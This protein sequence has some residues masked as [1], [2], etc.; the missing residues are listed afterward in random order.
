MGGGGL[1]AGAVYSQWCS[2]AAEDA[3]HDSVWSLRSLFLGTC[4][5]EA[6]TESTLA[7][8]HLCCRR[9]E[10]IERLPRHSPRDRSWL[11]STVPWNTGRGPLVNRSILY[12][13]DHPSVTGSLNR[14]LNR[15]ELAA[16]VP[17]CRDTFGPMR[18]LT[19][20][21]VVWPVS[22]SDCLIGI[23]QLLMLPGFLTISLQGSDWMREHC[24]AVVP[25]DGT[26]RPQIVDEQTNPSFFTSWSITTNSL[27]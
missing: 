1:A 13:C 22:N 12:C 4:C 10:N 18:H 9:S 19:M 25:L 14:R 26:A 20:N 8:F 3:F 7:S 17:L 27:V 11:G 24:R 2:N 15:T 23:P 21:E 5:N 6:K 16:F